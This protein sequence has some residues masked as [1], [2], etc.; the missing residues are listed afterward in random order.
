MGIPV[1][2]FMAGESYHLDSLKNNDVYFSSIEQLNDPYEGLMH[3]SKEGVTHSQRMSALTHKLNEDHND[4]KK[5]RREAESIF[6]RMP[7]A[8]FVQHIDRLCKEQFDRFLAYH[9]EKRFILSL[10]RGFDTDDIFPPPLT[11]MMMWGH[12]ANGMRGLCVEY[13]FEKLRSSINSLNNIKVTSK[14]IDYSETSL[15]VVRAATMLDDIAMRHH[16]T[17]R[18]V[19]N[20]FCTKNTAWEY[21]NEVRLISPI[22]EHNKFDAVAITRV[23]V[24]ANNEE[25]VRDVKEILSSKSH[26]PDLYQVVTHDRE[27]KFGFSKLEY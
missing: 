25:L 13:D 5:A 21:E 19:L 4:L 22:H 6:K 14:T 8:Q 11:N 2:K 24:S 20:A 18:E 7:T 15:P 27:Y 1:F 16:D 17:S 26:K 23:F 3:Y 12:Y 10:S 9:K